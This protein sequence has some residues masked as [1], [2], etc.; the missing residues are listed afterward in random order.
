M[1]R[2]GRGRLG[3][4][5][6]LLRGQRTHEQFAR[7]LCVGAAN[8]LF[9]YGVYVALILLGAAPA[10]ALGIAT[11]IGAVFNFH[12]VSGFVFRRLR[13]RLFGR[14]CLAYGAI[15]L[16]NIAALQGLLALGLAPILAQGLLLPAV[17]ALAFVISRQVLHA[18]SR[19]ASGSRGT[20]C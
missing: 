16:L 5:A 19:S 18:P 15:Y 4:M 12:T 17:A 2:A 14:Y 3:R 9:G 6:R 11:A 1:T 7:F 8:T 20:A 13:Y 10:L